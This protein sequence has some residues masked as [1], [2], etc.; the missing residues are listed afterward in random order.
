M[1]HFSQ[2]ETTSNGHK[3][4]WSLLL[5]VA[6]T[7]RRFYLLPAKPQARVAIVTLKSSTYTSRFR[8]CPLCTV[9]LRETGA[10]R[11]I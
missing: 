2:L 11:R 9:H 10:T 8:L 4:L 5:A 1:P 3:F 6:E 7:N